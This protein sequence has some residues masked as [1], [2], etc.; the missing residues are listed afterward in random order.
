MKRCTCCCQRAARGV[1]SSHGRR[2]RR[3]RLLPSSCCRHTSCVTSRPSIW[4]RADTA[5]ARAST[6]GA[7]RIVSATN[8]RIPCL[9]TP[10]LRAACLRASGVRASGVRVQAHTRGVRD[11]VHALLLPPIALLRLVA[12]LT[13]RS[14]CALLITRRCS[15]L[16]AR[17]DSSTMWRAPAAM[18]GALTQI[19]LI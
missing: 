15:S 8:V 7:G 4:A 10:Y 1:P 19:R 13:I 2:S 9:R 3:R 18:W 11:D 16:A 17:S 5:S 14:S 12:P 6:S